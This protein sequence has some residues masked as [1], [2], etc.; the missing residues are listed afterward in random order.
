MDGFLMNEKSLQLDHLDLNSN[1]KLFRPK[2]LDLNYIDNDEEMT[3]SMLRA[4]LES[5]A[6]GI[7]LV[8]KDGLIECLNETVKKMWNIPKTLE[9][10]KDDNLLLGCILDQVKQPELF[11]EKVGEVYSH[12]D[13]ESHDIIHLKDGRIFER[14]SRPQRIGGKSVGRVWSF[15]DIT[16]SV[17]AQEDLE[18][19]LKTLR[20]AM[21]GVIQAMALTVE[22]RD[23]Y[24]AGH[25]RRVADLARSIAQEMGLS[26]ERIIGIHLAGGIHDIG[27]ICVPSDILSKPGLLNKNEFA[28]IKDHS[29]VG[30]DILK[31]IEFPWPIAEIV[32]QHHEKLDGSGYP[33]GLKGNDILLEAKIVSLSDVVEAM[34]S[35]RPYRPT[36]G[37]DKA[38]EEISKYKGV[39]FDPEVVDACLRVLIDRGFKLE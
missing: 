34:A 6:D 36:L 27:K 37:I 26:D 23:P 38:L 28:I 32:Y 9:E 21:G 29:T 25:Q 7:I 2:T 15:R 39:Y 20:K 4:T 8:S 13:E 12:P 10:G 1:I 17:M 16:E 14:Y 5:T 19:S 33:R 31:E 3:V 24:T 18:R 35:H 22:K 30:Y 11:I